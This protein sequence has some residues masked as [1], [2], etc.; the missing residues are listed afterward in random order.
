M[1]INPDQYAELRKAA[2]DSNMSVGDLMATLA[3]RYLGGRHERVADS[4]TN[5]HAS[6]TIPTQRR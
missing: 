4:R 5:P 6:A 1:I 3:I 2:F